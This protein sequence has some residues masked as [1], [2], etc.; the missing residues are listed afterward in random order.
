MPPLQV[1]RSATYVGAR[2]LGLETDRGTIEPG[3][4]ADL[5]FLSKNPLEDIANMRSVILTVKGGT[6]YPRENY[7]GISKEELGE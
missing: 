7:H 6:E 1:I 4:R 2:V 3:K 5:V